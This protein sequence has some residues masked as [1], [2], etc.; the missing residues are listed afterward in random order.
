[1]TDK[2]PLNPIEV[3]I[4]PLI[5]SD[6]DQLEPILRQHVRDRDTGE[7][8]E[9][10]IAEIKGYMQG[11]ADKDEGRTRKYLVAKDLAGRVVGCMAYSTPDRDMLKH[12]NTTKEESVELLN[13]F[14]ANEVFRG[15]GVGRK[16]FNAICEQVKREGKKQLLV[17]S[18]PRYKASWGFYD[19][20]CD[21]N[22]GFI[23]EKYGKNGDA[24]TWIKYLNNSDRHPITA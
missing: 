10:E 4:S 19:K 9:G 20:V 16:L 2:E 24:N 22:T 23:K 13:A 11:E 5:S 12:F 14:V 18:G 7:I 8:L 15:G 1:M 17:N 21:E 6:I 3:Q